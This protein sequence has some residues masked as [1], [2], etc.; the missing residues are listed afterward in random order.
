MDEIAAKIRRR[1]WTTYGPNSVAIYSGTYG[2]ACYMATGPFIGALIEGA[3]LLVTCCSVRALIDQPGKDIA[4]TLLGGWEAGPHMFTDADVWMIVGG[5]IL[6][7]YSNS[8]PGQNPAWRLNDALKTRPEIHRHRSKANGDRVQGAHPSS[9]PDR[10]RTPRAI[11][12]G[13]IRLIIGEGLHD[14]AF[15][16]CR[17]SVEW[18]FCAR[19]SSPSPR[20]TS[21]NARAFPRP[22]FIAAARTF[23]KG[24]RGLADGRDRD[25][26]LWPVEPHRILDAVDPQHG[27][28]PLHPGRASLS[29]RLASYF[30][31]PTPRAQP[32]APRPALGLGYGRWRLEA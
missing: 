31:A 27:L 17:T 5:N 13:M 8:L 15:S 28:W 32:R 19:R 26:L 2:C 16:R 21:A 20:P 30:P 22:D 7:T 3:G 14:A 18:R 23:A 12:A 24:R 11:L 4:N 29:P 9:S 6:I 1:W 25:Q 10:A